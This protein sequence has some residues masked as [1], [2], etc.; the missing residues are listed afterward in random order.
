M[1]LYMTVI[2]V[3]RYEDNKS[4]TSISYNQF[5]DTDKDQYPTYSVCLE[6]DGLYRY[7]G[8]ATYEAYGINPSNYEKMLQGQPAFRYEYDHTKRLFIKTPLPLKHETHFEFEDIVQR[9][10]QVHEPTKRH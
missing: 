4:T 7:N 10:D 5:G 2:L 8:S 1:A 6:G 3:G 9:I